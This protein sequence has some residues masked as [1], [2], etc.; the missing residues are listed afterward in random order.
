MVKKSKIVVEPHYVKDATGKKKQVYLLYSE[1]KE[2]LNELEQ[3]R[4][5]QEKEGIRWVTVSR[6]K[7]PKQK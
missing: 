6:S 5:I 4:K 7:R 2:L 1:Y 3:Y